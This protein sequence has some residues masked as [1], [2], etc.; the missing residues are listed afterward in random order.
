MIDATSNNCRNYTCVEADTTLNSDDACDAFSPGCVTTGAG[1]VL[2]LGGC[3]TLTGTEPTC[4]L[5]TGNDGKCKF[6]SGTNCALKVCTDAPTSTATDPDCGTFLKGCV[7]TGKGCIATKGGCASYTVAN[8]V[9]DCAG[10]TGTDGVCEG[11]SGATTCRSRKCENGTGTTDALCGDY[12]TGCVTNGKTCVTSK[13]GCSSYS[14]TTTTCA[15]YIGI[16]GNC[17]GT[18]ATTAG[19]CAAKVCDTDS[20]ANP[21]S[22]TTDEKCQAI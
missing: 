3:A 13:S 4:P 19:P 16:E 22:F 11:D 14:G 6:G 1:C 12:K 20:A 10:Y 8:P 21:S 9:T 18:S 7:T 17:K 2:S 5:M 15:G